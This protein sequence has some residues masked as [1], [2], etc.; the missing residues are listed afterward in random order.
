MEP[1]FWASNRQLL[2]SDSPINIPS[3]VMICLNWLFIAVKETDYEKQLKEEEK[4]LESI[5]ERKGKE[6]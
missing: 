4:I 1:L 2:V 3:P 5:A 6:R